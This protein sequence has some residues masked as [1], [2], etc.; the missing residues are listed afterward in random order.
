M[1]PMDHERCS[2]LLPGY[3]AGDLDGADTE[4]VA[5]HLAECEQCAGERAGLEALQGTPSL[6][7]T[8]EERAALERGVMAGIGRDEPGDVVTPLPTRPPIRARLAQALGAAALIAAIAT[9]AFLGLSGGDD[10]AVL[11]TANQ[12]GDAE[13][14]DTEAA[15]DQSQDAGGGSGGGSGSLE[16]KKGTTGTSEIAAAEAG[17]PDSASGPGGQPPQPA[18]TLA[19][20]PFTSGELQKLGESSLASVTFAHYYSAGDAEHR[21][22]LL[23]QLVDDARRRAGQEVADQVEDCAQQVLDSENAILPSFGSLG[24]LDGSDALVLGFA[25]TSGRG[26]LDRYMVWGWERGDCDVALEYIEGRIETSD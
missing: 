3:L 4:A 1:S 9:F 14:A 17:A 7:M 13:G 10:D 8:T 26:S 11:R 23:E 20:D 2:E 18:F 19:D 21:V 25:W 15:F 6:T 5:E 16:D 12:D 22:T 24:E